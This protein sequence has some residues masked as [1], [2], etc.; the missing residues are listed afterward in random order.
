MRVV[1]VIAEFSAHEAMGRTVTETARRVPGEH[2]LITTTAHDGTEVFT[3]VVEL[4]GAV[5]TFPIGRV[6]AMDA[7]LAKLRPDVV[8]LH[9]GALSPLFAQASGIAWYRTVL[10]MYAWP[11]LPSP[12]R[13]LAGGLRAA[14]QSNVLRPRVGATTVL[15]S[16]VVRRALR[17]VS[18]VLTPDPRVQRKLHGLDV[19]RLGSGGPVDSRRAKWSA[20]APVV[21]FAGRAESVRGIDTLLECFP[22]VVAQVPDARLRLLLIPRPE[23]DAL[24]QRAREAGLG[25]S[26]DVVTDPVKD[27]LGEMAN[28]QVGAW[29]F[30]YDYTTSPP[31]MAAAE[32]LSVGL[33]V[34]ATDVACLQAVVQDGVNGSV[35]PP[36]D[37]KALAAAIVR[38]LRDRSLWDT[39]A[40]AGPGWVA[41][42]LSW[43]GMAEATAAAYADAMR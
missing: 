21:L 17:G 35:V 19:R 32:A 8:H 26:L 25:D 22:D 15:P 37:P 27:L 38:L 41:Q 1:H 30:K 2:A 23:L 40:Q 6:P 29:P 20:T 43:E 36:S 13:L 7:A 4:G 18:V 16:A 11:V 3:D 12:Q 33:P 9:G 24:L 34:V 42:R 31:A 28:A 39:Y 10:T 14:M 5:E